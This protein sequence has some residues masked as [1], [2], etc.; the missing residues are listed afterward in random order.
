VKVTKIETDITLEIVL[1]KDD[2]NKLGKEMTDYEADRDPDTY[3]PI[4]IRRLID[5]ILEVA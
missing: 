5:S 4:Q 2:L 1:S 3:M